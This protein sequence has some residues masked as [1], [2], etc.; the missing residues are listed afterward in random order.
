MHKVIDESD[1]FAEPCP[2]HLNGNDRIG[3]AMDTAKNPCESSCSGNIEGFVRTEEKPSFF[4]AVEAFDLI[5]RD[6]ST[7]QCRLQEM[8]C[9]RVFDTD[10]RMQVIDLLMGHYADRKD[11]LNHTVERIGGHAEWMLKTKNPIDD[12]A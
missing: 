11:T 9:R 2:K 12:S 4:A 8:I 6:P 7:P 1:V 5:V 3:F 10:F